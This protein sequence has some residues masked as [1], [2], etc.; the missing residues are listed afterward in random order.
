MLALRISLKD[1]LGVLAAGAGFAGFLSALFYFFLAL[2][3]WHGVG[4]GALLGGWIALFS[5]AFFTL[6]NRFLLPRVA[7]SWWVAISALV[8]F[9]A[10]FLGT[11][12]GVFWAS[13]LGFSLPVRL[14]EFLLQSAAML[15]VLTYILGALLY[16]LVRLRNINTHLDTL[17]LQSRLKSLETQLNPHFLF[18]A[19][20]SLAELY[21]QD[22]AKGEAMTLRLSHFLR[23]TMQENALIS[24]EK[25][26]E[27]T[28]A[29]V[30]I[31]TLRYGEKIR[32]HVKVPSSF[33]HHLVPKFSIQLLVENA[34]KHGFKGTPFDITIEAQ[35][36]EKTLHVKVSNSGAPA[37]NS[38]FGIGLSNLSERLKYLC[39]G[40]LKN[41]STHHASYTFTLGAPR[42]HTAG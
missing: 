20:N 29:Y 41:T 23:N 42:E 1:W 19:L 13:L 40:T 7:P 34:I 24:L 15:G 33:A 3:W 8:A 18:N 5:W 22:P 37:L 25:E 10:G 30:D 12:L 4:F 38:A 31:E 39:G 6:T 35:L 9:L 28:K 11:F 26:L 17:L 16:H 32:L 2:P 21:H 36:Q 27:N 14:E